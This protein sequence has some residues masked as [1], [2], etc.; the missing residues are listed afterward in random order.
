LASAR[1]SYSHDGWQRRPI[2]FAPRQLAVTASIDRL[3]LEG[4]LQYLREAGD[5][6]GC[7]SGDCGPPGPA[8]GVA[9]QPWFGNPTAALVLSGTRIHFDDAA[10]SGEGW[11]A[12]A[13]G[14]IAPA[15]GGLALSADVSV[16][17]LESMLQER[18]ESLGPAAV[19]TLLSTTTA[20]S[21]GGDQSR[22]QVVLPPNGQPLVNG[23]PLTF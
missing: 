17:G 5:R 23:R 20:G 14:G 12:T 10:F 18:K 11:D 9:S 15:A 16:H 7:L 22:L 4:V 2:G 6:L 1:L 8:P 13:S 21:A 19:Q 3:P